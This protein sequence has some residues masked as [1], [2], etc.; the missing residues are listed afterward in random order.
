V[1]SATTGER[2]LEAYKEG[3]GT[4]LVEKI[5][6]KI[7]GLLSDEIDEEPIVISGIRGTQDKGKRDWSWESLKKI[8]EK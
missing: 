1:V 2:A 4:R 5:G 3:N 8:W 7:Q 6:L